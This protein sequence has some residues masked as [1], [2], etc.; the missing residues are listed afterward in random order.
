MDGDDAERTGALVDEHRAVDS[1]AALPSDGVAGVGLFNVDR[2]RIPCLSE[3]HS[4]SVRRLQKPRVTGVGRE[5][6]QRPG[7]HDAPIMLGQLDAGWREP[8][9]QGAN[10]AV[11]VVQEWAGARRVV[12]SW[13]RSLAQASCSRQSSWRWQH[14]SRRGQMELFNKQ[15]GSSAACCCLYTAASIELSSTATSA[16]SHGPNRWCTSST[17]SWASRPSTRKC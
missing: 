14:P 9:W 15:F 16:R 2:Q 13:A 10:S 7:A 17:R 11:T 5:E 3:S 1:V 8:L 4:E 6:H 12:E